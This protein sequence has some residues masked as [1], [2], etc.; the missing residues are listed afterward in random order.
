MV[1]C[2]DSLPNDVASLKKLLLAEQDKVQTLT[3]RLDALLESIRLERHKRF[4]ASTEKA[5]GQAELFDEAEHEALRAEL[6]Q[7][8]ANDAN[9]KPNAQPAQKKKARSA[10]KPLPTDIP[11]VRNVRPNCKSYNTFERNTPV[12]RARTP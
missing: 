6:E 4:G 2:V 11:R 5:P 1:Q 9:E 8:A 12:K 7:Q 3:K 10:R